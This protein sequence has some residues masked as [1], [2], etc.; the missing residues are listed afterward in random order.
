MEKHRKHA[1]LNRRDLGNFA[2]LE[3]A[4]LGAKCSLIQNL[5]D[6]ISASLDEKVKIAYTL[7]MVKTYGTEA[8]ERLQR[9]SRGIEHSQEID[10][11][12]DFY[13]SRLKALQCG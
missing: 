5:A 4:M 12:N 7:W 1:K 8:V 6:N 11:W 9:L 10:E 13:T 3:I 2:A